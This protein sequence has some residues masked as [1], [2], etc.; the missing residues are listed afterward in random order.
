MKICFFYCNDNTLKVIYWRSAI[1]NRA[2]VVLSGA[3]EGQIIHRRDFDHRSWGDVNLTTDELD[4]MPMLSTWAN[5]LIVLDY[6][7]SPSAAGSRVTNA[8]IYLSRGFLTIGN[9]SGSSL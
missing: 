7:D 4:I 8:R 2:I 6:D 9:L 1:R 3:L 5:G